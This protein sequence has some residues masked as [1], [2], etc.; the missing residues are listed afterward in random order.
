MWD[1]IVI[2]ARPTLVIAF[3]AVI[4]SATDMYP[5]EIPEKQR[6]SVEMVEQADA[7]VRVSAVE[8]AV[9]PQDPNVF[10]NGEPDSMIRFKV[11]EVIRGRMSRELILPGYLVDEDDFNQLG[12]A[13][14]H[15]VRANGLTGSCFANS[16]RSGGQFLLILKKE[17]NGGYT[18]DWDI[19]GP[20]NE[21]LRSADDPW[22]LWV[23]EQAKKRTVPNGK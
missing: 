11:L 9:A 23:R 12:A 3:V 4:V 6:S 2:N 21:Q 1:M 16:Y 10:T 8:Y 19:L 7:I 15:V 18:V 5:C 17:K 22:L 20:T 14:R 13:E